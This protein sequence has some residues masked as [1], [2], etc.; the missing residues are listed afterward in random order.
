MNAQFE[1]AGGSVV[2]REHTAAGR[3]NQDA[4]CWSRTPELTVAVVADGCG[5]GAHSEVGAR[6]GVRLVVE[7]IRAR[8][9]RLRSEPPDEVLERVR[10]D[11]LAQLRVLANAMGGSFSQVV[12]DYLLFTVVGFVLT[13]SRSF[14]FS[15]GDGVA[16]I[17]GRT[18]VL[19]FS[20]NQP[21][22][23][24]YAL[25]GSTLTDSDPSALR[26]QVRWSVPTGEVESLLIGT[27]GA[28]DIDD[29][30]DRRRAGRGEPAGP[31]CQFWEDDRCFRNPYTIGR[32]L[33]LLNRESIQPDWDGRT[34]NR[35]HGLLPDDTALVVLRRSKE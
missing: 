5:S 33:A 8:S 15:L 7:S 24:A 1:I 17:N 20:A 6:L 26:F 32:R 23:L 27:D 34:L 22:Y 16:A 10:L 2:G 28:A 11:V 4:Y 19:R 12:G 29:A 31:L 14:G 21:P 35:E 25:T 18:E 30:A 3:N 13:P 9:E